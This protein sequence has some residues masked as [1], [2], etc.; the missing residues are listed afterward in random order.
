MK[1]KLKLHTL[2]EDDTYWGK[3]SRMTTERRSLNGIRLRGSVPRKEEIL[4]EVVALHKIIADD[5][6]EY[7][8]VLVDLLSPTTP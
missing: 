6:R 8:R 4:R 7:E 2:Y 5:D 1:V 3:V